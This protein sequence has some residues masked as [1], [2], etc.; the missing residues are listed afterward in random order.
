[1]S[2]EKTACEG[3]WLANTFRDDHAFEEG[4]NRAEQDGWQL[5]S[6]QALAFGEVE[7]EGP[8]TYCGFAAVWRRRP[9]RTYSR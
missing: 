6:W 5:H 7:E 2:E 1:M 8:V 9:R 3:T 4:L